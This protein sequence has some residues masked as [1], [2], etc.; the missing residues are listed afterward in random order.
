MEQTK[1]YNKMLDA[2]FTK[3]TAK[4]FCTVLPRLVTAGQEGEQQ[5]TLAALADMTPPSAFKHTRVLVKRGILWK[6]S[7]KAF[8]LRPDWTRVFDLSYADLS[9]CLDSAVENANS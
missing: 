3:G 7:Y 2:G 5:R 8:A 6:P 9:N 4:F 1:L